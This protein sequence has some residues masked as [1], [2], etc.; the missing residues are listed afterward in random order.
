[1]RSL[2]LRIFVYYWVATGMVVSI[3][4][5]TTSWV[6]W[7][8]LTALDELEPVALTD[9]AT[10]AL[11]KGGRD[12]LTDWTRDE[13]RSIFAPNIY[14]VDQAGHD[15]LGRDVSESLYR[16]SE[17]AVVALREGK[18]AAWGPRYAAMI[19]SP[20]G[21]SDFMLI[22]TAAAAGPL[23]ALGNLSVLSAM[24]VVALAI[25]GMVCWV[26]ARTITQP[27]VRLQQSAQALANGHLGT[28][29]GREISSRLT[30]WARWHAIST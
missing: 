29:V 20:G 14:M 28:R 7:H 24:M 12:G 2:F 15:L 30:S 3:A 1:M 18:S 9:S 8:R 22:V 16:R 11:V 23:A 6:G 10:A 26:V 21:G 4:V 27:V 19:S 17:L 25:V 5:I 13:N